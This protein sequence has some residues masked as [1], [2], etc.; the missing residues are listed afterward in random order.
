MNDEIC[1]EWSS[2]H[3]WPG[4]FDGRMGLRLAGV[5]GYHPCAVD[6]NHVFS[7]PQSRKIT[8]PQRHKREQCDQQAISV[9]NSRRQ[10]LNPGRP[11]NQRE[12]QIKQLIRK[13]KIALV[14]HRFVSDPYF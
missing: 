7:D 2:K 9:K 12:P 5:K 8:P 10:S 1:D 11:V 4:H 3:F 13:F 14:T 6:A